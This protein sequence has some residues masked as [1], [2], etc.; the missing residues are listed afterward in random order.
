MD[1]FQ[2]F[3]FDFLELKRTA[4]FAMYATHE[5]CLCHNNLALNDLNF[6]SAKWNCMFTMST[7]SRCMEQFAEAPNKSTTTNLRI[8]TF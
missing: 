4:T 2:F 6:I 3:R 7:A 8:T 5:Q 1:F